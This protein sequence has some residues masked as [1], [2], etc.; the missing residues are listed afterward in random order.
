MDGW[1]PPGLREGLHLAGWAAPGFTAL[2]GHMVRVPIRKEVK[3]LMWKLR[4]G[5]YG[6]A[7]HPTTVIGPV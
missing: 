1:A 4:K 3:F 6:G 7:C 5:R 2:I